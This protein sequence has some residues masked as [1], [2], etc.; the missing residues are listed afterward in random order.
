MNLSYPITPS[1]HWIG[2]RDPH[3][4][5]FDIVMETEY[6]TTYNSY[7]LSG[8]EKTAIFETV[9]DKF[10]EEYLDNIQKQVDPAQID[11]I[12]INHTEPDHTGALYKLLEI[13]PN[14]TVVGSNLAIKYLSSIVNAPFKSL[15]V[16]EGDTLSLGD[17]TI[18]FLSVPFLHWP[19]TIFSYIKEDGILVTCDSY[20]AHYTC[21]KILQSELSDSEKED[22]FTAFKYYYDMIMGPFK[23]YVL[24]SLD[25]I[26]KLTLNFI[27]PSHG[28]VLDTSNIE[29]FKSYYKEWSTPIAS[30]STSV[31]IPYVSAYGY[32]KDLAHAVANGV[33]Q[34]L[35]EATVKLHDLS[36]SDMNEVIA[37]VSSCDALLLGSS[38]LLADTLPQIW[39]ILISMNPIIHAGKYAACFGSYGWSAEGCK[40]IMDRYKQLK[41]KTPVEPFTVCFKPTAEDLQNA[42][43]F[44]FEFASQMPCKLTK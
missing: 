35:P 37:E 5:I 2:V 19:D 30:S 22:Y 15:V 44:G 18:E 25:K 11:Y 28:L 34:A 10:F 38:T 6:G 7:L 29:T 40:N 26:N 41:F 23:P 27:C 4:R 32:T 8:S 42:T 39:Q 31:I 33:Q 21:E 13:A 9:K 43:A 12:I 36:Y 24:K 1:L 20:G 3:L 17:K 16:K 14:A